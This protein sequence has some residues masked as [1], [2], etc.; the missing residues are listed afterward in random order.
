MRQLRT[1]LITQLGKLFLL[2]PDYFR[3]LA[4][5]WLNILF[6]ETLVGIGFVIWWALGAPTNHALVGV[7]VIAM[8]VAGYY[9]WRADH[10]RLETKLEIPRIRTQEWIVQQGSAN[11][12]HFAKAYYFEVLNISEGITIENVTVQLKSMIPGVSNLNWLPVH[13]RLKHDNPANVGDYA[14]SFNLN[15]H[16]LKNVDF[17]SALQGNTAFTIEHVV[18]GANH[19]VP[20]DTDGHRLEVMVT[21]KDIPA[22]SLWFKVWR[23]EFGLIQCEIEQNENPRTAV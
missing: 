20:F 23:D 21:A 12:G 9:A 5:E 2:L 8:F 10:L 13:L 11:A 4:K 1:W 22:L 15:P 7:F 3:A 16:E 18:A 19:T 14:R 6:G 17:V